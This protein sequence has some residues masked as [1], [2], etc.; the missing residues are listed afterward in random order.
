VVLHLGSFPAWAG[1]P[2]RSS[3]PSTTIGEQTE[4]AFYSMF[5]EGNYTEAV[6]IL[7]AAEG[8]GD[9]PLYQAMM[10]AFAY[11]EDD[12]DGLLEYAEDTQAVAEAMIASPN[13]TTEL[14]GHLYMAVG[15]FLEGAHVLRTDGLAEGTPR[16]LRMLQ[17]VFNHLDAAEDINPND[18]ELSLL[19]GFMDLL[20]AVNLPFS[21]PDNAIARLNNYGAPAYV[22]Q[23]GI[24]IGYRDLGQYDQALAAVDQAIAAAG[25]DNPDLL[26]LKAQILNLMGRSNDALDYFAQALAM[27]SQL[28]DG[29]VQQMR[30]EY[31][32]TPGNT[33]ASCS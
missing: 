16:A 2:F 12:Y 21:N 31:C 26:Y 24:A 3:N 5:R 32:A 19:K 25:T 23:R 8:E 6:A 17:Q 13:T 14:R 20:L 33:D 4:A 7:R 18:P 1:D 28:P 11:L 15:I 10:A 30:W 29:L 27:S 22:A 9:D